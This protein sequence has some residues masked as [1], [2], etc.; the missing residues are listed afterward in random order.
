MKSFK[1]LFKRNK[2]FI[3]LISL[4]LIFR[5]FNLT[6]LAIFN[7][8][9]IYLDWGWREITTPGHLYYSLYDAKQPL[10]MWVFGIFEILFK[11][12][13][14]WGRFVSVV[15]GLISLIG[16][17][18]VSRYFLDVK[19]SLLASLLFIFIPIFSF[20]DRQALMESAISAVGIWT[21]YFFLKFKETINLKY[22]IFLGITL[23][24]GF[25]IK[26]SSLIFLLT[27]LIM[28]LIFLLR[29]EKEKFLK[30]IVYLFTSFFLTTILLFINP[31]FWQTL[32]TNSRFSLTISEI[33]K[34]PLSHWFSNL[35]SNLEIIFFFTTPLIALT[36]LLSIV[37][38]IIKKEKKY[39]FLISFFL[40]SISLE[41]LL[42]KGISQRTVVAYLPLLSIFPFILLSL[43]KLNNLFRNIYIA[44]V[45][46]IPLGVTL[47]QITN[48]VS[49]IKSYDLFT[50]YSQMEYLK[51]YTSGY[52]VNDAIEI[53]DELSMDNEILIGI[54]QNTGNP[55]SAILNHY[56]KNKK[57]LVVYMDGRFISDLSSY[58][59]LKT[60]KKTYFV[61]REEELTG[62]DKF[63]SKVETIKNPHADNTIGIYKIK[64]NCEGNELPLELIKNP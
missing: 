45:L 15:A 8:E 60:S 64:E 18:K 7:D 63:L 11:D 56:R 47:L 46:L 53:I 28:S 25:F 24:L 43:V 48:P 31:L 13:L 51:G 1:D 21:F 35:L 2:E 3:L 34:F 5:L 59:C 4:Y 39:Y 41:I 62:F 37:L 58:E 16:I 29:K 44:I 10:L 27:V 52:S 40:I 26:S 20:Y 12:A 32:P 57:V 17:Y 38:V 54:A 23:G 9:A 22:S 49:Y 14:F 19:L 50:R 42:A 33:I 61:S 36:S 6:S 55:E 30:G